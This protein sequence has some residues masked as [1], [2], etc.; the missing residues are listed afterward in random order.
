MDSVWGE[1]DESYVGGV[2]S[3][4]DM[5]DDIW[6]L[7]DDSLPGSLLTLLTLFDTRKSVAITLYILYII[8]VVIVLFYVPFS[9]LL[10]N[11]QCHFTALLFI[12]SD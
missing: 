1:G 6:Y 4:G 9:C 11:P 2:L 8:Y 7:S 3:H 12:N 10:F 5:A